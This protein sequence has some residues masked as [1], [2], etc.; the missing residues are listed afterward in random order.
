MECF[1]KYSKSLET[2]VLTNRVVVP[3]INKGT[4]KKSTFIEVG[5][6]EN[7]NLHKQHII[8]HNRENNLLCGIFKYNENKSNFAVIMPTINVKDK[9]YFQNT[10]NTI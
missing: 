10:K 5:L 7:A 6:F 9:E 8:T 1:A 2:F 3:K 4:T